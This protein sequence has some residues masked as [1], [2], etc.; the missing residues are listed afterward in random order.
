[1]RI[2]T[3]TPLRLVP[4]RGVV[5]APERDRPTPPAHRPDDVA[6]VR[7]RL[8][9]AFAV[10][11][12]RMLAGWVSECEPAIVHGLYGL[13]RGLALA[14]D[15]EARIVVPSRRSTLEACAA[16]IAGGVVPD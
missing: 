2:Y 11:V 9:A 1:M 5:I 15:P 8:V 14:G 4:P 16:A 13:M 10:E 12:I 6:D 3:E 7:S